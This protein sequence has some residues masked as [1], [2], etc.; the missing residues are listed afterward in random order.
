VRYLPVDLAEII[1]T[2]SHE[3]IHGKLK[4]LL[5]PLLKKLEFPL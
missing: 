1:K 2:L 3:T 4:V 5:P